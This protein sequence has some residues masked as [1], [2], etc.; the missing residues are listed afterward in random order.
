M[1]VIRESGFPFRYAAKDGRLSAKYLAEVFK[2]ESHANMVCRNLRLK[3]NKQ[4]DVI[5]VEGKAVEPIS[6]KKDK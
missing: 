2:S 6:F 5:P 3:L 4:L 1:F